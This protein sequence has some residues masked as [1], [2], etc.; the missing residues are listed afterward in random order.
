MLFL[1]VVVALVS[2]GRVALTRERKSG[3]L[4][5]SIRLWR[6][7]VDGRFKN[8]MYQTIMRALLSFDYKYS[9]GPLSQRG[10][11]PFAK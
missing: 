2:F 7:V 8:S 3:L 4:F 6:Q 11:T 1:G 9:A 10:L 5:S